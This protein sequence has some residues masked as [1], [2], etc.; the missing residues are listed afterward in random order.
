MTTATT[1]TVVPCSSYLS[2]QS[3]HLVNRD[4]PD[5]F[6]AWEP[7]YDPDLWDWI[8]DFGESPECRSYADAM[9]R[10]LFTFS[11][12]GSSNTV[13]QTTALNLNHSLDFEPYYPV[14][15]P[16]NVV[17]E[18]TIDY[19]GTCCGNCSLDIPRVRL[20]YFP[21]KTADCHPN[22]TSKANSTLPARNLEKRV[23]SIVAD[24]SIAVIS[25]HTLYVMQPPP[26]SPMGIIL[27]IALLHLSIS[28][29]WAQRQ[30]VTNA[31]LLAQ[32]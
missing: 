13:I 15:I 3:T 10:G 7:E 22:Q 12:C 20:Y 4:T 17:Q 25:G 23:H 6:F 18:F 2:A 26:R 8:L 28:N 11:N 9:G 5:E 31:G 19:R 30:S 32:N 24:G 21:D 29:W 27:D 14:Q 16:P 1:T